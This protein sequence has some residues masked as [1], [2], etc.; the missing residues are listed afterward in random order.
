MSPSKPVRNGL[1]LVEAIVILAICGIVAVLI[2]LVVFY[3][4]MLD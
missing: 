4:V 3:L 2:P 1:T